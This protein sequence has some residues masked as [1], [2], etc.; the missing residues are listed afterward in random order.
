M[1]FSKDYAAI[2]GQYAAIVK[3]NAE[4]IRKA[5]AEL[6]DIERGL[7]AERK[8]MQ[9][10]TAAG[11]EKDYMA[12]K[13]RESYLEDRKSYLKK[14]LDM[15]QTAPM[16]DNDTVSRILAGLAAEEARLTAEVE[17]TFIPKLKGIMEECE[18]II[19]SYEVLTSA[20]QGT[21]EKLGKGGPAF[22]RSSAPALLYLVEKLYR[23]AIVH[24]YLPVP[25]ANDNNLQRP[26]NEKQKAELEN[27]KW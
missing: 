21:K 23:Q 26:L 6:P 2:A 10:A 16:A 17:K 11:S 18:D 3:E 20:K 25:S 15:L 27:A 22:D 5:E 12:A 14:R 1:K 13:A 8:N 4:E 9:A 19:S 24:A 7:E